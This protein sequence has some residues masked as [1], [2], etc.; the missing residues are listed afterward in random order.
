MVS[1]RPPPLPTLT[2]EILDDR[3][4]FADAI[5]QVIKGDRRLR[6]HT[7]EILKRQRELRE[8]VDDA[9]WRVYLFLEKAVNARASEELLVVTRWAFNEGRTTGARR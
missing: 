5:S 9:Q 2:S 3:E 4:R 6:R 8:V 7:I 1:R